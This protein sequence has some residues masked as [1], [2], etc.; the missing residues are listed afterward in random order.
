MTYRATI[1][2]VISGTTIQTPM[3][4]TDRD[5]LIVRMKAAIRERFAR[6]EEWAVW[7]MEER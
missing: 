5:R 2:N 6:P 4:D 1:H 7:T 3:T